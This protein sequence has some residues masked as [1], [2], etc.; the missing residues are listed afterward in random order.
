LGVKAVEMERQD[1]ITWTTMVVKGRCSEKTG[2]QANGVYGQ[3]YF[4]GWEKQCGTVKSIRSFTCCA[5]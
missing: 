5:F 4:L 1:E 3:G 2:G